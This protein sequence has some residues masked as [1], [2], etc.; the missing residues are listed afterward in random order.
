MPRRPSLRG[1]LLAPDVTGLDDHTP[2]AARRVLALLA[3]L[4]PGR[5]WSAR[6]GTLY[7]STLT[8]AMLVGLFWGLSK[9][10]GALLVQ[11]AGFY[12]FAW[13]APAIVLV[14]L[15]AFRYSTVQGFVSFSE[16]DCMLLLPAPLR[17]R[18]L[19][20]PRLGT[21]AVLVGVVGALAG[22]LVAAF[23]DVAA[24]S[25]GRVG[26]GA[27][28]GFALGVLVVAGSWHVQRRRRATAWMLR[29]TLPALGLAVLLG[30]AQ[31][32]HSN[33]RLA[34]LWSGPWGWSIL[35]VSGG[36][37]G[38]A[39][40]GGV[41]HGSTSGIVALALLCALALVGGVS[42]FRTAG[43]CSIEEF[44]SRARTRSQ[45]VASLH[46]FDWRSAGLATRGSK[47][48]SWQARVRIRLPRRQVLMVPWHSAVALLRSPVRL[49]WGIVLAGAGMVLLAHQPT[50]Q[51]TLWAGAVA[52]YLAASSLLEP[53][54]LEVDS[55]ATAR[56]F[57]PWRF[58]Q[59]LWL[60]CLLP[61]AVVVVAGVLAVA[62]AAA[63]GYVAV[64]VFGAMMLL[65]IPLSLV[66]VLAAAFSARRGGRVSSNLIE[67][68]ALDTTGF[69]F[70]GVFLRLAMW[71]IL[72]LVA[73][74]LTVYVLGRAHF[75][76]GVRL[77][78]VFV[79]L[80]VLAV[81]LQRGLVA[82]PR[83]TE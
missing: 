49:G 33:I 35:A 52:L 15:V 80:V 69:S 44:R 70:V 72:A 16:A 77:W 23:S 82:M 26:I 76:F 61:V 51:G 37:S 22:A 62:G 3:E 83:A 57:L 74:V 64:G 60:H 47:A 56:L 46:A 54:R 6:A 71:A 11:V 68:A 38:G 24:R 32:A 50:G 40:G 30:F 79:G 10:L 17:R 25:A 39:A 18:D 55:P 65:V 59:V 8:I 13:G 27:L 53:L 58:D 42:V 67:V 73:T 75:A 19:V 5:S 9:R 36:G 63:L 20:L 43:R 2:V 48:R 21:A 31:G 7:V 4:R 41:S 81:A 78:E 28:V 34:G 45:V 12:H 66:V 29:L 1:V 14:F